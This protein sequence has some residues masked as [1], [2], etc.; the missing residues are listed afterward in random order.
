LLGRGTKL[1]SQLMSSD[2]IYHGTMRLGI[3]TDSQDAQGKILKEADCGS[4]TRE[5]LEAEM[6]KFTGDLFQ[7]PPMVSAVK[8][9]GVP[10]Y[11]SARKG[12][13]IERKAR[14][15]HIYE[16]TMTK[17]ESPRAEFVLKCTKGVYV[18]T[19]CNDVGEALGCGAHLEQLRRVQSDNMK[20]ENATTMNEIMGMSR[21]D[22]L[23]KLIPM[24][25][26]SMGGMV[27]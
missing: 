11:K 9:D 24:S 6:A 1:S 27:E 26:F 20:I 8:V 18:R 13:V 21:E 5:Q 22:L 7:T 2:K 25:K 3:A 10:L 19:I 17:F 15:I 23:K 4:I 14:F 16:F 12:Q